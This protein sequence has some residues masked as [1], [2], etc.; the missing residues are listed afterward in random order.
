[1]PSRKSGTNKHALFVGKGTFLQD[2]YLDEFL[3]SDVSDVQIEHQCK[4][5]NYNSN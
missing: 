2:S 4:G 1:M 5:N 3:A